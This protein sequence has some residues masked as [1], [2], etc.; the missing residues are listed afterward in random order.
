MKKIVLLALLIFLIPFSHAFAND[1]DL[2]ILTQLMTQVPADTL[3]LRDLSGSMANTPA[4]ST[5]NALYY[6]PGTPTTTCNN[7][8]GDNVAYYPTSGGSNTSPCSGSGAK[9]ASS[10]GACSTGPLYQQC[11][12]SHTHSCSGVP[13]TLYYNPGTCT[14]TY[15]Y[16]CGNTTIPYY[17]TSSG[18][19]T[20]SCTTISSTTTLWGDPTCASP[21]YLTQNQTGTSA[22]QTD[23][24]QSKAAISKRALFKLLDADNGTNTGTPDGIINSNDQAY[25]KIRMAYMRYYGCASNNQSCSHGQSAPL[26]AEIVV[27]EAGWSNPPAANPAKGYCNTLIDPINTAY[28]TIY[29]DSA[30]CTPSSTGAANNSPVSIAG[31]TPSGGTPI[32]PA[33]QDANN[34]FQ[35]TQSQDTDAACRQKFVILITDGDDTMSCVGKCGTVYQDGTETNQYQ[36]MGR[37]ETVAQA[38]ALANQ[39]YY[40]FVI[41]FG[42]NMPYY[43]QN[44]LNWA[45]YYGNPK[46]SSLDTGQT[47]SITTMY[48]IPNSLIYPSGITQCQT[49]STNSN[50]G[51]LSNHY[52]ATANDPGEDTIS[53]YAFIA[54]NE[55]QLNAAISSIRNFIINLIAQSTSYVAPVVPISQYQQTSS[56]NRLY[57]GMFE[58]TT[59]TMW[60]GNIKKYGISSTATSTYGIGTMLDATGQPAED[61]NS[62]TVKSTAESYWST[63]ADGGSVTAGGVG[64]LIQSS[65]LNSRNIYTYLGTNTDLT[66]SSNAF[67]TSNAAITPALL[68]VSTTTAVSNIINFVHGYDVW[69]W[70]NGP[71]NARQWILGSFIH[72]RPFVIH[73]GTRDVIYA[74]SNDGMLHAFDDSTGSELWAFIPPDLLPNLN[75]FSNSLTSLQI[76]VDGSPNAYVNYVYNTNGSINSVSQ[77][78]L[79]FGERRGGNTYTALDVTSPTDPKFLWS[80]NPTQTWYQTTKTAS[81]TYGEMGQSWSTPMLGQIKNGSATKWVAFIGGGYDNTQP[82]SAEDTTPA[83]TDASGRAV[84]VVDITNGNLIWSYKHSNDSN[85]KYSIPSDITALSTNGDGFIER[86]Y[87]GDVGGQMWRFNLCS[88]A[89]GTCV[90]DMSNTASWNGKRIFIAGSTGTPGAGSAGKI[91]Y[92]PDVTFE[93]NKGKGFYDM[94]FFGTGDREKPNDTAST[95]SAWVNS[96]LY[97]I[98]DY[99][100]SPPAPYSLPFCESSLTDVTSDV[101]QSSTA[102]QAAKTTVLNSLESSMGWFIQLNQS[103]GE[104]LNPGE[105][106]TASPNVYAGVANYTTFAPTP[107]NTQSVCT[108]G[109]GEGYIYSLQY[110]TGSSVIDLNQDGQLTVSDRSTSIGSGLPSGIVITVI[111]GI[112]TGYGG[113]AGGVFSPTLTINNSIVPLDWRIVF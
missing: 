5:N 69:N 67:S 63:S 21:F 84:Y 14:T 52:C 26:V 74:G 68:G 49:S 98:K 37:R 97:A 38:R 87:I 41:G 70:N 6:N 71:G 30:S 48:T 12:G 81:T 15:P 57:L 104:S 23:C 18:S 103:A 7:N 78:I 1:T 4:D 32:G 22:S 94:L 13:S 111:N 2:Y 29:C 11:T 54:Q 56:E 101:L 92:P 65:N 27:P 82:T 16:S 80:I 72:S 91:L 108:I 107:V 100:G 28:N 102:T 83:G 51:G 17:L 109:T 53:G 73:Y 85:M 112:V 3:I 66:T 88:S 60:N 61:P 19:N 77:A 44:T 58:P 86:L 50:C 110:Q 43:Q 62:S 59:E 105:K 96:R 31:E 45:A 113:V 76:F 9:C 42:S 25:L 8:C 99:D 34:Y 39:G 24:T 64:A 106:C 93:T 79:I 40:V 33:L 55:S 95:D 35:Y 47:K 46:S 20:S 89:T 36:Y 10:T 90:P 75:N